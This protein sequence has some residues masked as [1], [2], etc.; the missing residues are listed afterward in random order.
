MIPRTIHYCWFG[1]RPLPNKVKQNIE[2]WK[3]QCPNYEIIQWNESNYDINANKYTLQAYERGKYAFVS[4]YARL[5]ILQKHGGIYLDTD[6]ELI[7]P[8]DSFLS[9]DAFFAMEEAG[10][11]ATGLGF[12]AIKNSHIL[13]NLKKQYDGQSFFDKHKENLKTCIEYSAPIF[14]DLG[15]SDED[16]TQ[17]FDQSRLA[18]FATEVF[19][20]QSL[21]TGKITITDKTVSIHH[22]DSSWKKH[23]RF[24]K[25]TTKYK[26]KIRKTIDY[27]LGNG[28]YDKLKNK[29]KH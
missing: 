12:G 2:S 23:P 26:I 29:L 14:K 17:Y 16:K 27:L 25:Y 19:C 15:I 1:G 10:A 4:D 21:E 20:P 24:S 8:L 11:V 5:D 18:V 13:K 3:K 28:T 6:V 7:K 9:F 22:Y